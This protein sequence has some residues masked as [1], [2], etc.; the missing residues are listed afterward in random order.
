MIP[1]FDDNSDRRSFPV[2][3][4]LFIALNIFVFIM[5]QQFGY[6]LA[7]TYSFATVPAEI[8]TGHDIVTASTTA[9]DPVTGQLITLP[10]LGV[11][12]VP[13]GHPNHLDVPA[14]RCRS[15]CR[16]YVI[17]LDIRR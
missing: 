7:F 6:N 8:L 3:N 13:V 4:Y 9:H 2:V 10:G 1:L 11:T 14:R 5:Y 15:P 16:Q 17:S 12:P